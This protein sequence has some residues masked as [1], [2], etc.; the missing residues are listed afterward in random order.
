MSI[1]AT[2][3]S[4]SISS[5]ETRIRVASA[6]GFAIDKMAQCGREMM[7]VTGVQGT[8]ISVFRG[9]N[10]SPAVS[11]MVGESISVGNPGDFGLRGIGTPNANVV[12]IETVN[13]RHHVTE[14]QFTDLLV[15]SAV[16]AADLAFGVLLYTLPPG[17]ILVKGSRIAIGVKGSGSTCDSDTPDGGLGTTVGSGANALLS[18][19]GAAAENILTGQTFNDCDG[20]VEEKTVETNLAIEDSGDKTVYFN[21]ADGWAGAADFTATG[22]VTIEWMLL[23]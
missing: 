22:T 3:L 5:S 15:G 21:L 6:T 18:A 7:K 13:G 11:H 16:G 9:Y 4:V 14:L 10:G 17:A 23:Q 20:A 2:T 12:A 19:V 1:S 8:V